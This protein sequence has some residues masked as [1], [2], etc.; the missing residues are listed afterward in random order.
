MAKKRIIY[1]E[2]GNDRDIVAYVDYPIH[3]DVSGDM[4]I[5]GH[6]YSARCHVKYEDVQTFLTKEEWDAIFTPDETLSCK[7]DERFNDLLSSDRQAIFQSY[8]I[9]SEKEF[10]MEE[11]DIDEDDYAELAETDFI[12]SN[13]YD[14][15]RSAIASIYDDA[16]ELATEYIKN[17]EPNVAKNDLLLRHIDLVGLGEEVAEDEYF[18]TLSDGRIVE[19]D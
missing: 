12:T 3:R 7:D 5:C 1:R 17:Y 2:Y 10:I 15:D 18:Y 8:I 13:D 14:F 4:C 16:E 19:L 6:C 9:D 11:F